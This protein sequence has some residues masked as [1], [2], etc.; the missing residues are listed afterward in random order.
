VRRHL[1]DAKWLVAAAFIA[2]GVTALLSSLR[3]SVPTG[4]PY[5]LQDP[6]LRAWLAGFLRS[7]STGI[8]GALSTFLLVELILRGVQRRQEEERDEALRAEAE[9]K[10]RKRLQVSAI[11]RLAQAEDDPRIRQTILEEMKSLD[12]LMG[13]CF[14]RGIDLREADLNN[15]D[16]SQ[17]T[18]VDANLR[19]ANLQHARLHG[20]NMRLASLRFANLEDA[21]LS[22]ADLR[23]ADMD[24]ANLTS[25]DFTG[26]NLGSANLSGA[27]AVGAIFNNTCLVGATMPDGTPHDQSSA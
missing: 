14:P 12:L 5:S 8:L 6:E 23:W 1:S 18:L 15:T 10:T 25:A 3:L 9:V 20:A 17:A 26:A 24:C 16:L 2:M 21:D 7:F 19:N 13:V 11:A 22:D 27:N 4:P